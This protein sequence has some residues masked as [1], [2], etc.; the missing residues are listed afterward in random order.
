MEEISHSGRIIEMTPQYIDVE[1]ISESACSACHAASLCSLSESK[2]KIVRVPLD[3]R[4]W[5]VG[6]EVEVCLKKT[7]GYKA[8]WI[9]YVAPLILLFAVLMGTKHFGMEELFSGLSAIGAVA[10]YYFVIWLLRERLRNEYT[11]YIN[12]K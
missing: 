12:K 6:E 5:A 9:S 10:L 8:V 2:S 1:I 3:F 7:M 11:F 4:D